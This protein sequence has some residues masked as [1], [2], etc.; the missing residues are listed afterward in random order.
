[1][2][3]DAYAARE[4]AGLLGEIY[5]RLRDEPGYRPETKAR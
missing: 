5:S 2:L 3:A 4:C 1:M